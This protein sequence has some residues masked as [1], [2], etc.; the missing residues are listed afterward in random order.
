MRRWHVYGIIAFPFKNIDDSKQYANLEWW[1]DYQQIKRYRIQ[2]TEKGNLL[3]A[4]L[5]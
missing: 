4:V 1:K 5:R 2:N 3:N